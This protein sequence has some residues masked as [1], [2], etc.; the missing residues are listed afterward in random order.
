MGHSTKM[1]V[2]KST[3]VNNIEYKH[4]QSPLANNKDKVLNWKKLIY[5]NYLLRWNLSGGD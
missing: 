5:L 3:K 1:L 2:F 4:S